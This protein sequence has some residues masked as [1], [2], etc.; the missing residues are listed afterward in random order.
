MKKIIST[1]LIAALSLTMLAGGASAAPSTNAVPAKM[2]VQDVTTQTS[3]FKEPVHLTI[4]VG[5]SGQLADP[6]PNLNFHWFWWEHHN[7]DVTTSG[8][9]T[10]LKP[11]KAIYY[12]IEYFPG[13]SVIQIYHITVTQ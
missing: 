5:W 11:G 7:V 2:A 4:P 13:R 8:Y 10:A 1:S 6:K 12:S 3:E 9:L